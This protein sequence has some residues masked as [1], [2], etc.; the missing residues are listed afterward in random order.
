MPLP[1]SQD[2]V[3][4]TA[5]TRGLAISSSPMDAPDPVT[6]FSTPLGKPA[7]CRTSATRTV[8]SGARE[9]GLMTRLFPATSAGAIFQ[10]GMAMGKFQGVSRDTTPSGLRKV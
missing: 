3:K 7:S 10:T 9:A 8:H 4:E 5:L 6:M 2:P 1:T